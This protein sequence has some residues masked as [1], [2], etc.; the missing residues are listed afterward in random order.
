MK[1][2]QRGDQVPCG[3]NAALAQLPFP[4]WS[5]TAAGD[6]CSGE[7]EDCI[8]VGG[9]GMEKPGLG[10]PGD[11]RYF[12]KARDLPGPFGSSAN[13]PCNRM[14]LLT[15]AINN[16]GTNQPRRPGDE[17]FHPA[18]SNPLSPSCRFHCFVNIR[19]IRPGVSRM[20][21]EGWLTRLA[22]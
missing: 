10:I 4:S 3:C 17:Y 5:P 19:T 21:G 1:L 11:L 16:R 7:M 20:P 13:Q 9:S 8:D 18:V 15:E 14:S 12:P 22:S 6:R 2:T